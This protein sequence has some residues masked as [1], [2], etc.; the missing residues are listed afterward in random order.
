MEE[1]RL[2]T[3]KIIILCS[4]VFGLVVFLFTS[5]WWFDGRFFNKQ[6]KYNY[7]W[8]EDGED[9]IGGTFIDDCFDF[10][11]IK[12]GQKYKG[13]IGYKIIGDLK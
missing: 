12:T 6:I 13:C 5:D 3:P 11:S 8:F 9:K 4:I 1:K 7:I 2:G 10:T